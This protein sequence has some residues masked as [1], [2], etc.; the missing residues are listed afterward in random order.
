MAEHEH[1]LSGLARKRAELAGEA[2]A[3]RARLVQVGTDLGHLDAAIR[4]F[5]PDYDLASIRPK[6]LR[7]PD[8]ARPGEM[9]RFVLD[10]L[11][12]VA[13]PMPTPDIAARLIVERGLDSADRK[14]ART[15]TKRVCTA[16]RHQER[17]GT[18]QSRQGPGRVTLWAVAP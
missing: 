13:E 18:V 10:V 15:L 4:L 2:D 3:L 5:D 11:R 14:L 1:V 6:R 16:L 12:G 8:M 17:R 9:S 7:D